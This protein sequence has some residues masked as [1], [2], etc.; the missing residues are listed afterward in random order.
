VGG[1]GGPGGGG[2]D[3]REMVAEVND[4]HGLEYDWDEIVNLLPD[5]VADVEVCDTPDA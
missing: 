1:V 5:E 4:T 3:V 2:F